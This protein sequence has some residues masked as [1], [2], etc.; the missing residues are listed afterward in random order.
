[1]T[2]LAVVFIVLKKSSIGKPFQS[3]FLIQTEID[4]VFLCS[5]AFAAVIFLH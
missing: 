4:I 5:T 1:M 3:E 2:Q